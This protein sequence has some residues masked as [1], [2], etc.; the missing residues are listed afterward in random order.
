MPIKE[1]LDN[2]K[3]VKCK[4]KLIDSFRFMSSP[5]SVLV[6]NLSEGFYNDQFTNCIS[7]L[8]Y[9]SVKDDQLIFSCFDCKKNYKDDFN[10][11]LI[12]TFGKTYEFCGGDLL[13]S[14]SY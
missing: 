5:L 6:D 12:K 8:D 3:S 9:M 1:E 2:G 11:D 10:K 14:L 4:I 7:C 13:N